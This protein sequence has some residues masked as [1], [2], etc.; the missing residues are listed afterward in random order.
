M[1]ESEHPDEAQW[2]LTEQLLAAGVDALR[3]A[4]WQRTGKGKR[5]KPIERPGVGPKRKKMGSESLPIR[6]ARAI[7]DKINRG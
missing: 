2:G 3:V 5:P 4:N 6:A 7:L 1:W